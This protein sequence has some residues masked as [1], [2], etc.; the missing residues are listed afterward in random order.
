MALLSLVTVFFFSCKKDSKNEPATTPSEQEEQGDDDG[1]GGDDA[2][3]IIIDALF[4]EWTADNAAIDI[5]VAGFDASKNSESYPALKKLMAASDEDYL[6]LYVEFDAAKE[7]GAL[8]ILIDADNNPETGMS[9]W[10]FTTSGIDYLLET[11]TVDPNDED[12][13]I[14]ITDVAAN[15]ALFEYTDADG[16]DAWVWNDLGAAGAIE[17][18]DV[19]TLANGNKAVEIAVIKAMIHGSTAASMNADAFRVG[20]FSSNYTWGESGVM[21]QVSTDADGNTVTSDMLTVNVTK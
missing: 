17:S 3:A 10:L 19:V 18:S 7:V 6:Y 11:A 1:E 14:A 12:K 20:I 4:D 5:A 9:S 8:D 16:S 15:S 21:P 2:T 13:L